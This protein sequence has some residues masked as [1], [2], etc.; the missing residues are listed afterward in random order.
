MTPYGKV[1]VPTGPALEIQALPNPDHL[2]QE[3]SKL[4]ELLAYPQQG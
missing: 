2:P 4:S 1:C 3:L